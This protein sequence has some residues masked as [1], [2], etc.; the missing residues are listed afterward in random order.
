MGSAASW[1]NRE[2]TSPDTAEA[3]ISHEEWERQGREML[4]RLRIIPPVQRRR[5]ESVGYPTQNGI[6]WVYW[7]PKEARQQAA[8]GKT[9]NQGVIT[10]EQN[11]KTDWFKKDFGLSSSRKSFSLFVFYLMRCKWLAA[12]LYQCNLSVCEYSSF[13]FS[14]VTTINRKGITGRLCLIRLIYSFSFLCI[15]IF[16]LR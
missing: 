14:C 3:L 1:G 6:Y 10:F 13:Y 7:R 8:G 2:Q 16:L 11:K 9:G 4:S 15:T 5:A 12:P